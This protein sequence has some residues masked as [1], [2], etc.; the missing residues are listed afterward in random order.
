VGKLLKIVGMVL[1]PILYAM[2]YVSV[3]FEGKKTLRSEMEEKQR[4]R[5]LWG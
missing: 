5:N 4:E 3:A 1:A 2:A